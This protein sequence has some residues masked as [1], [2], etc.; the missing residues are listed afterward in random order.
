MRR[1]VGLRIGQYFLNMAH[2]LVVA[3]HDAGAFFEGDLRLRN[4]DAGFGDQFRLSRAI[5]NT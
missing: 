5:D 4:I 2:C 3:G 1:S